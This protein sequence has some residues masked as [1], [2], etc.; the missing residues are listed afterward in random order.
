[1]DSSVQI[2]APSYS[3]P[4]NDT[5][6][7]TKSGKPKKAK[8]E[9]SKTRTKVASNFSFTDATVMAQTN[10]NRPDQRLPAIFIPLRRR[11]V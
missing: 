9:E 11:S 6:K 3:G 4:A 1:M 8:A 5:I 2:S 7:A 10:V